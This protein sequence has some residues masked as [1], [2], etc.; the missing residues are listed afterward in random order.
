MLNH[1]YSEVRV[2]KRND[3]KV[4]RLL[5]DRDGHRFIAKRYCG[6]GPEQQRVNT[7]YAFD[8]LDFF[9]KRFG[10]FMVI[11]APLGIDLSQSEFYLEYVPALAEPK[12]L[13]LKTVALSGDFFRTCYSIDLKEFDFRPIEQSKLFNAR[14]G[15][16]LQQGFPLSVGLKGDLWQNLNLDGE[17]L[18]LS[19]ID[20]V[21]Q[22]PL[23]FSEF[24]LY[25]ELLS[26][27]NLDNLRYVFG[28]KQAQPVALGYLGAERAIALAE[29]VFEHVRRIH[30]RSSGPIARGKFALAEQ[31]FLRIIRST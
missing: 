21:S 12:L 14:I 22:E 3:Y 27:L 9:H 10:D 19:D 18:L 4:V 20:S 13:N 31:R 26:R 23:G 6:H 17:Q 25:I 5:C 24:V 8:V 2:L 29:V 15:A 7:Q 30:L 28:T 1:P 16:L 11:P